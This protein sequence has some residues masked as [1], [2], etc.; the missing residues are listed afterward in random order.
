MLP[1]AGRW[2]VFVLFLAFSVG[3]GLEAAVRVVLPQ[4]LI[5]E[6]PD[7]WEPS[8]E[9]GW[10]RRP[11]R[12]IWVNTG[13]RDVQVCTDTR[14]DRI[15]CD[16][17]ARRSCEQRILVMGDSF[18]EALAVPFDETVWSRL[19]RD[20]GACIEVAGVGGY[21]VSQ[22]LASVR[23]RLG[24]PANHY[25][26]VVLNFYAGNDFTR[27]VA[28][29]P[30]HQMVELGRATL[31]PRPPRDD[32]RDSRL[33]RLRYGVNRWL[34]S[35]SHAYVAT[36]VAMRR[37]EAEPTELLG[38]RS[39][40]LRRSA[41]R[42]RLLDETTRGIRQISKVVRRR[43]SRLLV[44]V[45]PHRAQVLDPQGTQLIE[46]IP[47]FAGDVDMDLVRKRFVPRLESMPGVEVIDLLPILRERATEGAWGRRDRHLNRR[48]HELWFDAVR[49]PVRDLLPTPS[50]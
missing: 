18:V 17:A 10:R 25:D 24:G 30:S 43:G 47:K 15:D 29:I 12:R 14:G 42:A 27:D 28:R 39:N 26:L 41:L 11:E 2:T 7:L 38:G 48:G 6:P 33:G 20:T 21:G 35:H 5:R 9:L 37:S 3:L 23:E 46:L 40:A 19:E 44:V 1:P 50:G 36:I 22:Y 45:I 13:D 49:I 8:L 31:G 32:E 16:R 4:A 34:A